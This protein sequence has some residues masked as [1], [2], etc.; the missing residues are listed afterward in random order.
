MDEVDG[1]AF[2]LILCSI[3]LGYAPLSQ[4]RLWQKINRQQ[5]FFLGKGLEV[6]PL[7]LFS[8][9]FMLRYP[10]FMLWLHVHSGSLAVNPG[11]SPFY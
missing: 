8:S 7:A 2:M 11:R 9:S 10:L 1:R 5:M 4:G 6:L 3:S